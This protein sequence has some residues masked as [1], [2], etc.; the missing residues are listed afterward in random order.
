MVKK[1]TCELCGK[2]EHFVLDLWKHKAQD[3]GDAYDEDFLLYVLTEQ[4]YELA[5]KVKRLESVSKETLTGIEDIMKAVKHDGVS[6][7]NIVDSQAKVIIENLK[8]N[9]DIEG[10]QNQIKE[11]PREMM[12]KKC[13]VGWDVNK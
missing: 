3:H 5:E 11:T 2:G 12:T 9:R 13:P 4:N 7:A 8:I 1:H 10:L 6:M